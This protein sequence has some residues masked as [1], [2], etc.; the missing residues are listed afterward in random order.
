MILLKSCRNIGFLL[1]SFR[2]L[3][4]FR[5]VI[6]FYDSFGSF[7]ILW[8]FSKTYWFFS[9]FLFFSHKFEKYDLFALFLV[10][11]TW[12]KEKRWIHTLG[13]GR[14]Y[15]H[16]QNFYLASRVH[17]MMINSKQRE[18][19]IEIGF[20]RLGKCK[21]PDRKESSD[22]KTPTSVAV[23]LVHIVYGLVSSRWTKFHEKVQEIHHVW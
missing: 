4:F 11:S 1:K 23:Y 2:I 3:W 6:E 12:V 10:N 21:Q 7:S 19:Q 22:F 18:L 20:S 17:F 16:T 8:F 9:S 5:K 14:K 15:N 13:Q